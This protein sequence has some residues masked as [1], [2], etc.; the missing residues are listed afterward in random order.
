[1]SS[2]K[3]ALPA[4]A[5]ALAFGALGVALGRRTANPSTDRAAA[6]PSS[7]AAAGLDGQGAPR[8]SASPSLSSPSGTYPAV[9]QAMPTLAHYG[10]RVV[11]HPQVVTITFA[12]DDPA[13]VKAVEAMGDVVTR[14]T[15]WKTV[16]EGLCTKD[17]ECVGEGQPGLRARLAIPA[18][19]SA[20]AEEWF[21]FVVDQITHGKVPRPTDDTV[22]VLYL[23]RSATLETGGKRCGVSGA[24]AYHSLFG[25]PSGSTELR[26]PLA[27]V[28]RCGDIDETTGTGSH[29][30]LESTSDPDLQG[31]QI[32]RDPAFHSFTLNGLEAVDPCTLVT[33]D[34]HR[35]HVDG[36]IFHRAWSSKDAKAG[37]DP[38]VPHRPRDTYVNAVPSRP[39]AKLTPRNRR[40]EIRW[41]AIS[42]A[43]TPTEW[44][45]SAVE[46]SRLHGERRC[47]SLSLDRQ[48]VNNGTEFTLTVYLEDPGCTNDVP[49]GVV[50]TF[51]TRTHMWPMLVR[52]RHDQ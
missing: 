23:P 50:S 16:T 29:E 31:F 7:V 19:R 38:C 2:V 5:M 3:G 21:A 10:G 11:R 47:L 28:M 37:H 26:Y 6:R 4:I 45:I 42:D 32:D 17:G 51:G 41:T 49:V 8:A 34:D 12:E 30:V 24:R 1:M 15:W 46:L 39:E 48:T 33:L 44:S 52:I 14:G 20:P 22:H 43:A 36:F 40:D 35:V 18:L 27:I 25:F 9:P 13:V